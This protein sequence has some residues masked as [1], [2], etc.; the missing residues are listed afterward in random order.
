[1][2]TQQRAS[3]LREIDGW[4]ADAKAKSKRIQD[5]GEALAKRIGAH[6]LGNVMDV[7]LLNSIDVE[8]NELEIQKENISGR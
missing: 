8:L 2:N 1:M 6:G 4:I 5:A 7:D 3:R